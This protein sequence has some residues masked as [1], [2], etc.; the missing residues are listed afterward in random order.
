MTV[1]MGC[2]IGMMSLGRGA[3]LALTCAEVFLVPVTR[4]SLFQ[5]L[6]VRTVLC[7]AQFFC[8]KQRQVA[9]WHRLADIT[10]QFKT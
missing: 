8:Q 10:L 1:L 3:A 9:S 4:L 2:I 5:Q 6:L 7:K